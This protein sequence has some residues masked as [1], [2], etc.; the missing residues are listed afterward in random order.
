MGRETAD[1]VEPLLAGGGL[2]HIIATHAEHFGDDGADILI[3]VDHKNFGPILAGERRAG[4][5][6]GGLVY[7]FGLIR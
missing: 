2:D 4:E 1:V 7:D 6:V 5:L 3:V